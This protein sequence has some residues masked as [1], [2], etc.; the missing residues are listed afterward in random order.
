MVASEKEKNKES[1]S[2][3]SFVAI[4]R[5]TKNSNLW[6][7]ETG[8]STHIKN[9]IEGLYDCRKEETIVQIG[10]RKSLK[11]TTVGTLKATVQQHDVTTIDIK[12]KN[13][14]YVPELS[15]N[16]LSITKAMENGCQVS[17]KGNIMSLTKRSMTIKLD[18]LQKTKNG[19]CPGIIMKTKIPQESAHIAQMMTYTEA[20]QKL[21]HLGEEVA[22]AT[23]IKIGWKMTKKTKECESCSIGK[24]SQKNL[25]KT[26]SRKSK[27]PG[28][29]FASDIS[30]VATEA[31]GGGELLVICC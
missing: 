1:D 15:I 9:T 29:V 2:E 18:K 17:N 13:V 23:A 16:L 26:A 5:P 21:R 11:S 12:L 4:K 20:H 8:S 25:N 6:I 27:K 28:Q 30:S 22:K 31:V 7:G 24:A 10:N 3:A 14:A 19:F